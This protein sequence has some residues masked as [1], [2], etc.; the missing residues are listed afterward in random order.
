MPELAAVPRA[1]QREAGSPSPAGV[2]L[3]IPSCGPP[4]WKA[5]KQSLFGRLHRGGS[6]HVR[7]PPRPT[8]QLL[9]RQ[10]SLQVP[11]Y[12]RQLAQGFPGSGNIGIW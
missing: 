7:L 9:G 2:A 5:R 12:A 8:V 1:D 10:V 11:R 3:V 6:L 4:F